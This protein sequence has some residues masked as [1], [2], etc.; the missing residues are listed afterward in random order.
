MPWLDDLKRLRVR[1]DNEGYGKKMAEVAER[2]TL[3]ERFAVELAV[4]GMMGEMND[5]LLD[6]GARLVVDRS[7]QYDFDDEDEPD[8]DEL[9]DEI[10]YTLYWHDGE[11]VEIEIR[12]GI[13][14][15]DAGYVIVEDEEVDDD[16]ESIQ[17][18]LSAAFRDIAD[19]D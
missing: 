15:A 7:W 6:G 8:D 2:R 4:E 5:I 1:V 12:V 19:M 3:L 17:N 18:A 10:V 9:A 13:D 16:T 11:P 14:D